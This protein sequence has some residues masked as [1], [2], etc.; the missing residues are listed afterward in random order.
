MKD[1]VIDLRSIA[2]KYKDPSS[3]IE[4]ILDDDFKTKFSPVIAKAIRIEDLQKR[5]K[6]LRI[7]QG[8]MPKEELEKITLALDYYG[9]MYDYIEKKKIGC[10][11]NKVKGSLKKILKE[12]ERSSKESSPNYLI[13]YRGKV[14]DP[15]DKGRLKRLEREVRIDR[16]LREKCNGHGR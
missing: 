3:V 6:A 16:M 2:Y 10:G 9:Y 8:S 15:K 12:K 7:I 14:I 1:K 5:R 4:V 13:F 11:E